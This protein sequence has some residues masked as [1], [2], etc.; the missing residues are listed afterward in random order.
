M[1]TLVLDEERLRASEESLESEFLTIAGLLEKWRKEGVA[2]KKRSSIWVANV[3]G[4]QA[5]FNIL[6]ENGRLD[7]D[8]AG[9]LLREIDA[10][11][12]W[13]LLEGEL[14][15]S[16][17]FVCEEVARQRATGCAVLPQFDGVM[18]VD[19]HR[20][21]LVG[22]SAQ[23]IAFYR[24]A[25]NLGNFSEAQFLSNA[26]KAFPE[27]YLHPKLE[28]Q[29]SRFSRAFGPDLRSVL[30]S[31]LSSLNDHLPSLLAEGRS[32]HELARA[33]QALSG[34]EISPESPNT[35]RNRAAMA[36]RDVLFDKIKVRCEWHLKLEP[37][38]DRIHFFFGQ[39]KV[40]QRPILVGIFCEHLST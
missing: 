38:R 40:S 23:A 37:H 11:P 2:V 27:L 10:L 5:L 13:D 12:D 25:A 28:P 15:T 3:N 36:E 20:V 29:L 22:S 4:E 21:Y 14:R 39:H 24:D 6:F 26:I 30:T 7:R 18:D 35:H 19:G 1:I 33:F 8:I 34:F 17:E 16:F 9:Q 31:A 32:S